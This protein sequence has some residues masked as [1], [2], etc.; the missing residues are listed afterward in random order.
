MARSWREALVAAELPGDL[1]PYS[2]RHSSIVRGLRAGLPVRLVAA[3]H[4]TSVAMIEKHYG[5]FIVDATEDLLRRALV[6]MSSP[7]PAQ[8]QSLDAARATRSRKAKPA[9]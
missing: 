2:L 9:G 7:P 4:D 1:V 3:V 8:V 6:P 5:A